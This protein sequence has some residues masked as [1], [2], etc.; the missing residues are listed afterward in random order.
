M[1]RITVAITVEEDYS[2]RSKYRAIRSA[3]INAAVAKA[4]SEDLT[5]STIEG[6]VGTP[7]KVPS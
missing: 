6:K 1:K 7:R 4:T 3:M 2:Y 5:I